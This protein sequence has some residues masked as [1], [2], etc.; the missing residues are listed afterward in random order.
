MERDLVGRDVVV[1]AQK[2]QSEMNE[3]VCKALRGHD[4]SEGYHTDERDLE[5]R[6]LS[7][8]YHLIERDL[9]CRDVMV[10]A[11]NDKSETKELVQKALGGHDQSKGY[12]TIERDFEYLA[13]RDQ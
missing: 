7:K 12:H 10:M 9:V 11:Q 2:D 6:I 8:G 3:L 4:P 13:Y 1:M 5:Y